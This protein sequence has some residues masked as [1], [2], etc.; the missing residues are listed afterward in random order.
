MAADEVMLESAAS[1]QASLRFYHWSEPTVSLGY[2]QPENVRRADPRLAGLAYVRRATGGG[3]L[4][5]HHE[6]TY[7]LALPF[8]EPWH[9]RAENWVARFHR[10]VATA[11][12]ELGIAVKPV[13]V[14]QVRKL[15][16]ALCFLDQTADDLLLAGHKI[17]GSARRKHKSAVLQHGGILLSHSEF[18]PELLGLSE[19]AGVPTQRLESL[20]DAIVSTLAAE[21]GWHLEPADWSAAEANRRIELISE[22]YAT[23]AWNAKR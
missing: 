17:L 22:K 23:P 8:G 9:N 21:T 2:F 15:G 19:L 14:G 11:L 12:R 5:H 10:V 16:D 18:A 13:G 7:A 3:A 6:V 4:V 1:G 20:P